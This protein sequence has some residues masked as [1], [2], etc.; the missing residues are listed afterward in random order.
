MPLEGEYRPSTRDLVAEQVRQYEES[1]GTKGT[2]LEG[3]PCVILTTKGRRTGALR[4]SPLM[5]VEHGGTYAVVASQG[6]APRHPQ[7]YLNLVANPEVTLQDGAEVLDLR[8]R[9]ASQD[10]KADWWPRAT[11]VWP[12]YDEYQE[13]TTRD[14]PLVLL[15]PY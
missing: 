2:T 7:W 12:P 1:G 10:E 3:R 6:G 13:R 9:T 11:E 14:I 8:A 5:R 15:E 4:K